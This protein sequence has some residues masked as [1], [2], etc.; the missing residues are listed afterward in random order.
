MTETTIALA[1]LIIVPIVIRAA[2][3]QGRKNL[4]ALKHTIAD[5]GIVL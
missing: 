4:G 3:M 5:R 2:L 1:A